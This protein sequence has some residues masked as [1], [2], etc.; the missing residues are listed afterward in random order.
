MKEKIKKILLWIV[1]VWFIMVFV[2]SFINAVMIVLYGPS[3]SS[4]NPLITIS[5]LA[6]SAVIIIKLQKKLN[7]PDLFKRKK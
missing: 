5:L 6:I 7:L 4:Q 1:L 2:D 3:N